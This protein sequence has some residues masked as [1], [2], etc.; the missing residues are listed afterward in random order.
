MIG[1]FGNRIAPT[2]NACQKTERFL[3]DE[4]YIVVIMVFLFGARLFGFGEVMGVHPPTDTIRSLK[5]L[6]RQVFDLKVVEDHSDVQSC[7]KVRLFKQYSGA[8]DYTTHSSPNDTNLGV[9]G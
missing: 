8:D 4:T 5:D 2:C 1:I 7:H 9:S 3:L 6:V